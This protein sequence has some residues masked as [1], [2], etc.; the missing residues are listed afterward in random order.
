MPVTELTS[1]LDGAHGSTWLLTATP[2]RC[3]FGGA[4]GREAFDHDF[5]VVTR[6]F[7]AK[8]AQGEF[9][10]LMPVG[11]VDI[12]YAF[13]SNSDRPNRRHGIHVHAIVTAVHEAKGAQLDYND[14]RS[15]LNAAVGCPV[16]FHARIAK[17]GSSLHNLR[18]YLSKQL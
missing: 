6:R 1:K 9:M 3:K 2:L 13:E 7:L 12:E 10:T 15:W 4:G 11:D 8:V 17:N 5:R 18:R 16:H 14:I